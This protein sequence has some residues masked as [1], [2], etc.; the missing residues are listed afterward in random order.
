M[1]NSHLDYLHQPADTEV[2]KIAQVRNNCANETPIWLCIPD[3]QCAV[4][5]VGKPILVVLEKFTVWDSQ[6]KFVRSPNT[7]YINVTAL[8]WQNPWKPCSLSN[9][10]FWTV[11]ELEAKPK[12]NKFAV[13]II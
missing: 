11:F 10:K 9:I 6:T 8:T 2:D 12:A 13:G 3:R 4:S 5:L 1:R 7:V